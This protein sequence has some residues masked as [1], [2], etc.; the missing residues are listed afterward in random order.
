MA[1]G[2]LIAISITEERDDGMELYQVDFYTADKD[3]DYEIEKT[4]G[5]SCLSTRR[6]TI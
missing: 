4:S 6:S 1:E 2:D 3:Y 5:R